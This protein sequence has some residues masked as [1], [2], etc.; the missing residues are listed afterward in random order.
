MFETSEEVFYVR[1]TYYPAN[2]SPWV[3]MATVN[4]IRQYKPEYLRS[5]LYL[6][7]RKRFSSELWKL[8]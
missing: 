3:S 2:P 6:T 5:D 1:T 7:D 4:E 8:G